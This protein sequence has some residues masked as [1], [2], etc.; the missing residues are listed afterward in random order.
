M[1]NSKGFKKLLN[2]I[3]PVSCHTNI[4]YFGAQQEILI[5]IFIQLGKPAEMQYPFY[6]E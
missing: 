4:C 6:N 3:S 1:K 5:H 2:M